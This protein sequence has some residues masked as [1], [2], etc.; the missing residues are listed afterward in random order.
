[1]LYTATT[2]CWSESNRENLHQTSTV[3]LR[4]WQEVGVWERLHQIV[5]DELGQLGAIDWER[6]CIDAVSVRA[7]RGGRDLSGPARQVVGRTGRST[8]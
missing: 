8:T 4:Q 5:L 1:M 6:Y 3:Q 7:Q 2:T